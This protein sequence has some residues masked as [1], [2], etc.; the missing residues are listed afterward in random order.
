MDRS[1]GNGP[2]ELLVRYTAG[3]Y[4]TVGQSWIVGQPGGVPSGVNVVDWFL[5][6]DNGTAVTG[7]GT[8]R[9]AVAPASAHTDPF[10]A[11]GTPHADFP[12]LKRSSTVLQARL[13]NDSDFAPLQGRIRA[14]ANATAETPSATH[15]LRFFDAAGTEYRVLAVAV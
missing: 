6:N 3:G 14:H 9:L 1:G 12:A 4:T 10:I 15:T 2:F 8:P 5:I 13:G 7:A 11:W